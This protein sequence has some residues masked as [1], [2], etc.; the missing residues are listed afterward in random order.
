MKLLTSL[1]LLLSVLSASAPV[2]IISSRRVL[3]APA[4]GGASYLIQESFDAN[5][6]DLAWTEAAGSP[7]GNASASPAPLEGSESLILDG[8]SVTER[9]DS[10]TFTATAD[11]WVYL[12]LNPTNR[13]TSGNN[14]FLTIRASTT[15]VLAAQMN[16]SGQVR[17]SVG[18]NSTS[19]SDGM[20]AGT[21][22]HVWIHYIGNSGGAAFGSIAFSASGTKPTMGA[23]FTSINTGP[24]TASADNIRLTSVAANG[25]VYLYDKIRVD[26]ADIGDSPP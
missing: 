18:N 20:S 3:T 17:V 22:Y 25:G 19:T 13:P 14:D 10:P 8:T 11:V 15:Q 1:V 12:L 5:E 7:N 26:D 24:T 16:S 6:Y 4:G 23:A 21:T 9:L 2:T